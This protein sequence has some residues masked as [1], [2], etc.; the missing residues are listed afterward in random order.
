LGKS[1]PPSFLSV[2]LLFGLLLHS[3]ASASILLSLPTTLSSNQSTE[4][5]IAGGRAGWR[6]ALG[7]WRRAGSARG[8]RGRQAGRRGG[9]GGARTSGPGAA[10]QE[11]ALGEGAGGRLQLAAAA[12]PVGR[13]SGQACKRRKLAVARRASGAGWRWLRRRAAQTA[14]D[15]GRAR[16]ERRLEQRWLGASAGGSSARARASGVA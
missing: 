6:R 11:R 5:A 8:R 15:A 2:H 12:R 3:L 13:G 7:W 16:G 9:S 4:A 10:A 14:A 1:I